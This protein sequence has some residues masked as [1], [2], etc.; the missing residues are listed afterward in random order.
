MLYPLS[1]PSQYFNGLELISYRPTPTAPWQ[2]CPT[3]QLNALVLWF[4]AVLGQCGIHRLCN[5]I[6]T[7]FLHPKLQAT[8]NAV[9]KHCDAY[10]IKKQT[11]PGYG[12]LPPRQLCRFCRFKK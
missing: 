4:H 12:H 8:I 11:G 6:A 2:I 3:N 9:I 7:R 1:Y 10:Q 5:S